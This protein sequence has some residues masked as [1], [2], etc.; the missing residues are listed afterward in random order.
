M[1][2]LARGNARGLKALIEHDGKPTAPRARANQNNVARRIL[3]NAPNMASAGRFGAFFIVQ[4]SW[5]RYIVCGKQVLSLVR[6]E[7][8]PC[9]TTLK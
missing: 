6:S 4:T 3:A 2:A 1:L 8:R 7:S 5:F 9:L